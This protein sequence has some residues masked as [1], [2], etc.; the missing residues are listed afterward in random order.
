MSAFAVLGQELNCRVEIN[1]QKVEGSSKDV[2]KSLQEAIKE[3]LNT[4]KWTQAQYSPMERIECTFFLTI[5]KYD[6]SDGRMEGDL[7]I[8]STR[9]VYNTNYNST[10]INFKDNKIAFNYRDGDQLNYSE[11]TLDNNLLA[12]LNFYAYLFLAVD[13][14]TF[15]PKGGDPYYDKL[16]SIVQ[17]AQNL[18]E[19][20]WKAFEDTKNRPAVLAALTDPSTSGFRDL[21]YQYH[22]EGLDQMAVAPEKGRDAITNSLDVLAKVFKVAPMSVGLSIFKDA[23]LDEL[24]NVYSKAQPEERDKA[25]EILY[26]IFP[27]E[28]ARLEK[29]KKGA[30]EK[31]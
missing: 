1:T 10:L 22:R 20:G 24:V 28:Q 18:G 15:S 5:N 11:T 16:Q 2:F 19:S 12:L 29:I 14:D 25:Y 7:Q 4:T 8:Q 13:S 23:K 21:L 27:V 26:P 6:D 31:F 9:P 3:Y 17:M 30:K